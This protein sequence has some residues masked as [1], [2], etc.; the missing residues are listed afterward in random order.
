[1]KINMKSL[2]ENLHK[3]SRF[4]PKYPC[5]K[6][7]QFV[8]KNFKRDGSAKVL[9]LGCGTGRHVY[10]MASENIDA[11]GTDI[12]KDGIEYTTQMLGNHGL[13]ADLKVSTVDKI[14]YENEYFDGLI[15]YGVLYYCSKEE[16]EVAVKEIKRVLKPTGKAF[17]I[18]RSV[19]DYRFGKG[20][21]FEK[22]T[23]LIKETDENKAAFNENGM[24]MHFF[25][26]E[27]V[28]QLF[29]DFSEINIDEIIETHENGKYADCNYVIN[30][31]K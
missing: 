30:L 25:T 1:M 24:K 26:Y 18:V 4:R 31:V 5:E 10:F 2:W 8:F 23:F 13:K 19:K 7:V 15:C 29:K 6:V 17:I 12:S 20:E 22:N 21:E 28:Q 14:P 27:E 16:I 3:Q 11:Y 9:D